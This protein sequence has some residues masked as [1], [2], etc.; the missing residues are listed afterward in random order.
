M[1]NNIITKKEYPTD[2]TI[3]QFRNHPM[4]RTTVVEESTDINFLLTPK[5]LSFLG[6]H[7]NGLLINL[8]NFLM[9]IKELMKKFQVI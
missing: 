3:I 6:D 4:V 1:E 8:Q 2:K 9:L 5:A 7:I